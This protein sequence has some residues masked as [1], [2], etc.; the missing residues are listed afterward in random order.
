MG[1]HSTKTNNK[2]Y[3]RDGDSGFIRSG[4]NI[5]SF[6]IAASNSNWTDEMNNFYSTSNWDIEKLT[7][8]G[9][10]II[11]YGANN[12]MPKEL[13]DVLEIQHI[14]A[15]I[16]RRKRNILFG[17]GPVLYKIEYKDGQRVKT[18]VEDIEIETWLKSWNYGQYLRK[19]CVDYYNAEL[20][21]TKIFR[22]R[23]ARIGGAS[24]IAKLEHVGVHRSR[25]GWPEN[26][27][28]VRVITGDF[29]YNRDIKV[30]PTWDKMD[31]FRNPVSMAYANQYSF[32]R[33]WYPVPSYYGTMNWL[34]RSS[35][36]PQILKSLTDNSL[37][38]KWHIKSPASYWE[39]R[40]EELKRDCETKNEKYT[41]DL[42]EDLKDEVFGKLGDVLAG[43]K[44]V[45][46]FFTS[47]TFFNE[48]GLAEGWEILPIDQKIQEYVT[49][50]LEIAKYADVAAISGMGLPPSLSNIMVDGK[51]SSGSESLYAYKLYMSTEV[52]I[53]ESIVCQAINDAIA[54]N[55]PGRGIQLGFYHDVVKTEDSVTSSERLKNKI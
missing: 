35:A 6:Q 2:N 30:F 17:Q 18:Y 26:G 7:V 37:N 28:I 54:V 43:Q 31:P 42:L 50:Q 40:R 25:F 14:G 20:V 36:V 9:Y 38:I 44:N 12:N 10:D 24:Q 22:N 21:F 47:E 53:D 39:A 5:Y 1:N 51:L 48:Q 41:E 27:S 15:G 8:A 46:K 16:Q 29:D 23:A 52:D 3:Y 32:A 33:D 19:C 55:F 45:G 49:A 11:P 13:R 4:N 34:N